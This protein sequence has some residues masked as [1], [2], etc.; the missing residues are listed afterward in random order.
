MADQTYSDP[1]VQ[2]LLARRFVA[3]KADQDAHPEL[4][5]RYRDWGWPATI[6]LTA[7]GQDLA[8]RAGFMPPEELAALL[9]GLAADPKPE[10]AP[11]PAPTT[12]AQDPSLSP[13]LEAELARRHRASQ[14]RTLGAWRS[15]Q[16]Y[17]D[18]DA[19]EWAML[20]AADGDPD[21]EAWARLSLDQGL[22]LLDP[23]WGGFYQY[24]TQR[25]WDHPHYEKLTKIQAGYLRMYALAYGLWGRPSDA[26]AC[27]EV[28]RYVDRFLT[29]PQG[30]FYASQDA[31]LEP[32]KKAS[33][34]FALD[35]AARAKLGA[36]RVDTHLYARENGWM[37]EALAVAYEQTLDERLLERALKAADWTKQHR[38]RDGGLYAHDEAGEPDHLGDS[39]AM[40]R[41]W[42]QL[43]KVTGRRAFLDEARQ[44]ADA[45]L[46]NFVDDAPGVLSV[47]AGRETLARTRD[48]DDNIK[49]VRFMNLLSHY[50]GDPRHR[51]AAQRAMRYLATEDVAL[52]SFT[53]PG[54]LL[55]ARELAGAPL[56]LTLV[57]RRQDPRGDALYRAALRAWGGAYERVERWDPT[58]GPLPNPD[59]E[60]PALPEPA[61]FVCTQRVCSSP[62]KTEAT[63]YEFLKSRK[64]PTR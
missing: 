63:L 12:F 43:Y 37:I 14:D 62:L 4:S 1:H 15:P 21:E 45:L 39:L 54:V 31:D 6:V 5:T 35:D 2:E 41:A 7:D 11:K 48:L 60:Y 57:A 36:P 13:N 64:I 44:T 20:Q 16:K 40:A 53:E 24:S 42:L 29:S 61:L 34:F 56:H 59:V 28:V 18:R 55:G 3:V 22:A 50:T 27:D 49:W 17:L 46:A 8:K 26:R 9:R 10:D 30:A 19:L 32:G 38:K 52:A 23:A 51:E 25:S 33:D 58:E 47:R